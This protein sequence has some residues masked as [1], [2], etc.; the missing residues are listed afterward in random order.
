MS[1]SPEPSFYGQNRTLLGIPLSNRK[2]ACSE[3]NVDSSFSGSAKEQKTAVDKTVYS[4]STIKDNTFGPGARIH[5]GNVIN[6]AGNSSLEASAQDCRRNLFLTDPAEDRKALKRK[7]GDRASGTCEWLLETE[8]FTAWLG[9][10]QTTVEA[11]TSNILWL[12]GN[13]GTGKSTM[14]IFLTE[15]LPKEF[16]TEDGETLIYF[17][18]DS[19]FDKR[20]TATSILRGL[21][22]Q[23]IQQH[24]HLLDYLLPEYNERGAEL[25][26][27]FDA[28]WAIFIAAAADQNTGQKYCIIDALDEC[29]PESQKVLLR[30]F[31][32][33]FQSQEAPSNIRF[34]VTSR[35]YPEIRE[36]LEE[37]SNKDLASFPQAKQDIDRCIKERVAGL[38]K[39]KKYTDKVKNQVSDILREKAEG[40]FLWVGLACEELGDVPSKNAIQLLQKMPK[41]LHSLYK[42]L[43][44]TTLEQE[45]SGADIVQRVLSLVAVCTRP[46]S[47]LELSEACQIYQEEVDINTRIQFTRDQIASCRLLIILQDEKVLLLH[48]SVKDYLVG[49]DSNHFISEPDAHANVANRCVNLLI[50]QFHSQEQPNMHF[51]SYATDDWVNH[52]RMAQSRFEVRE[53]EAEFFRVNSPSREHWIKTLRRNYNQY[54][55]K[56]PQ[57][58]SILHVAGRWGIASLVDYIANQNYQQSNTKESMSV[59]DFDCVDENYYRP[60]DLAVRWGHIS[61]VTKLLCLGA[62]V[63]ERVVITAARNLWRGMDMM[64]LLLDQ[65]G[66]QIII[67]EDIVKAAAENE[68]GKEMMALLLDRR[69]DQITITEDVIKAAVRSRDYKGVMTLI[70]DRRRDQIMITEKFMKTVAENLE[71]AELIPLLLDWLGERVHITEGIVKAAAGNEYGEEVMALL[72]DQRG[73]QITITEEILK[74]AASNRFQAKEMMALLLDRRGDQINITEDVVKAAATCGQDAILNL[75]SLQTNTIISTWDKWRCISRFY[76]AARA[77]DIDGI[78]QLIHRGINPD[79]KNTRGETP[80]WI[81]ASNGHGAVVETLAQRTDVNVNSL[82]VAGRSPLFWPSSRGYERVVAILIE[83]GADPSFVDEDGDTAIIIASQ[84]G[85]DRI[86]EIL[87]RVV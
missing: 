76:N 5:Q 43:L 24:S 53:S 41:G 65:R 73:D 70:L 66:D 14:A 20:K 50:E 79:M 2:K 38:A 51:L 55:N 33:T 10:E 36:Y 83:A 32:E 69:G 52:A 85:H 30:Q 40:T 71:G 57:Q 74:T 86:V 81:A 13:P 44:D 34:L 78:Q 22:R 26:T 87:E 64:T 68:N 72:L 7:K 47:V 84:R 63:D 8:E 82:S 19:S 18:C 6:N 77:G 45:E 25:F 3:D 62:K 67:T 42:R 4:Q 17:F 35:P 48:Q 46:L 37:F 15:E 39:K 61:V 12:H 59:I 9:R 29:D 28:L 60:I 27:S 16:F 75:L 11:Q 49:A 1:S 56:I 31:Q 23:L 58:F 54:Y 80:L 21:L